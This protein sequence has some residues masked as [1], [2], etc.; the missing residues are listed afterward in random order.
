MRLIDADAFEQVLDDR[1]ERLKD[2]RAL[3]G[4]AAVLVALDKFAPTVD[5][6]PIDRVLEIIDA[7]L[8]KYCLYIMFQE[9]GNH[10]MHQASYYM[11]DRIKKAVMVLKDGEHEDSN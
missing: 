4:A 1:A 6:V 7:E 10:D 9:N 5:A 3:Y 8:W 11:A 2:E